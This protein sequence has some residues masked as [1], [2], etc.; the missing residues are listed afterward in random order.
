MPVL[1]LKKQVCFPMQVGD[2][3]CREFQEGEQGKQRQG[4][5]KQQHGSFLELKYHP[6]VEYVGDSK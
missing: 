5:M 1:G 2:M 3:A 6:S 4:D